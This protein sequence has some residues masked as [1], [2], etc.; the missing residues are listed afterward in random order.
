MKEGCEGG[1]AW[2]TLNFFADSESKVCS[3]S[4]GPQ[5]AQSEPSTAEQETLT[6]EGVQPGSPS[7][8][9]TDQPAQDELLSSDA[10]LD[11]TGTSRT[12]V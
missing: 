9:G 8:S 3:P 12:V 2:L 5:P 6:S 10:H 1:V 11:D 4:E 7:A